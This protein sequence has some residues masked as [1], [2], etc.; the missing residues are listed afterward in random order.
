MIAKGA[1]ANLNELLDLELDRDV[2]CATD[3][4]KARS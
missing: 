2:W 4:F 3:A 1:L